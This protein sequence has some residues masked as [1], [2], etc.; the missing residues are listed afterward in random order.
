MQRQQNR[1]VSLL[2]SPPHYTGKFGSR[3]LVVFLLAP[4]TD[5]HRFI[6]SRTYGRDVLYCNRI[7]YIFCADRI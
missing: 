2:Q 4:F 3:T 5:V 1:F 7:A 6:D